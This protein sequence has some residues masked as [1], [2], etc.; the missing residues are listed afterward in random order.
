MAKTVNI[1]RKL[2]VLN[3][4]VFLFVVST[5][6][7]LFTLFHVGDGAHRKEWLG[8]A[9]GYWLIIHQASAVGF[10]VGFVV[11]M[12]MHWKYLKTVAKRWRINLPKKIKS[13]TLEQILLFLAA[14]VVLWAGFY[15]WIVMPGATLEV[16][17]YHKWINVHNI[18]GIFFLIGM[19]VHIKRRWRLIIRYTKRKNV[20]E[21]NGPNA[22]REPTD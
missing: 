11:H 4:V 14:L 21:C 1:K 2:N 19:G 5:G 8:L 15:P 20:E 10:L 3:L 16:E 18:V 7:I 17:E 13:R 12:Q 6:L 9:K 22:F